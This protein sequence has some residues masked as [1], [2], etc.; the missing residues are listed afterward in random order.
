MKTNSAGGQQR[1]L[2]RWRYVYAGC[3][4]LMT[5]LLLPG[6]GEASE[7]S[8]YVK[9]SMVDGTCEVELLS[10]PTVSLGMHM[11]DEFTANNGTAAITS[12][13]L[14][15]DNCDNV[16]VAT[17]GRRMGLKVTG[18]TLTNNTH[19][20]NDNTGEEVGFMLRENGSSAFGATGVNEWVGL[21]KDFWD[22]T[23]AVNNGDV[24][25]QGVDATVGDGV[26]LNYGVGFVSAQKNQQPAFP[27][28]TVSASL[29]FTFDYR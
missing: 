8:L 2:Q 29:T 14:W 21:Q 1:P 28:S 20:F 9:G 19:I 15:M 27:Q 10:P 11:L 13:A 26:I 16:N 22:E 18:S 7:A 5:V 25:F 6:K 12:I 17:G 4:L 24:T 23:K 3:T